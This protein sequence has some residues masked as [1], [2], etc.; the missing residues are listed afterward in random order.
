MA[1]I[2][3]RNINDEALEGLRALAKNHGRSLEAE[4]RRLLEE[5]GQRERD[6]TAF[7]ERTDAIA[8][9]LKGRGD[10]TESGEL[11]K[12]GRRGE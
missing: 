8:E 11:R 6:R 2:L 4:V 5:L 12:I 7:W 10:N 1:Q 9:S 3:V